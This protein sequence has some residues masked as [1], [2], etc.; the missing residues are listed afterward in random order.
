MADFPAEQNSRLRLVS[1]AATCDGFFYRADS[2]GR[3]RP[4]PLSKTLFLT[5][6]PQG[7]RHPPPRKRFTARRSCRIACSR[8]PKVESFSEHDAEEVI[9]TR[10]SRHRRRLKKTS[11]PRN[12]RPPV[13]GIFIPAHAPATE[14]V[15]GQTAMK[16]NG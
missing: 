14:T 6:L 15:Q 12:H 8:N 4:Y 16:P 7:N 3:R 11:K 9:A 10:P 13:H 5:N 1:P 2:C